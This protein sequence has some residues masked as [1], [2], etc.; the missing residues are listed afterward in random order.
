MN[1]TKYGKPTP[2]YESD[3]FSDLLDM[4]ELSAEIYHNAK[5]CGNWQ[6]NE[7]KIGATCFH[8][9]TQGNCL[10]D[11][12]GHIKTELTC[13]DL[14]I[15]P[16][17][18]PHCVKPLHH[19][20]GKQKHSPYHQSNSINGTG[21]LC[22][23]V[24][25][26]HKSSQ[27]LL[28]ELPPVFIIP[29]DNNHSWSQF[30]YEMIMEESLSPNPASKTLLNKLSEMLFTYAVRQHLEENH[31]RIG[32]LSLYGHRRLNKTIRAIHANPEKKW[33]LEMMASEAMLSRTV[34]AETFKSVS[35]WT[36]GNYL[37]WWRMQLA[38][39]YLKKGMS[40]ARTAEKVGY[41]SEAAFSRAF[42]KS[43]SMSAG[44]VKREGYF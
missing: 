4:L 33:S 24:R 43:F 39:S 17:E 36:P 21:M 6:I 8:F 20:T 10:L 38:W 22:A 31:D 42:R 9:V 14:V 32:M 15:F 5:V 37:T 12:P 18:L 3:A 30:L 25:F 13:G 29:K 7:H 35:G 40:V 2:T 11:V 19:E 23:E 27:H 44:Q 1:G 28:N 34:F 16:K 26:H 41:Q